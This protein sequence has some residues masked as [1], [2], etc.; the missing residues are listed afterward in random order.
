[1]KYSYRLIRSGRKTIAI[2]L[3]RQGEIL[4]RAPRRTPVKEIDAFFEK[5]EPWIDRHY[6][7]W[8]KK[9][10][11]EAE[12]DP[13][14]EEIEELRKK[15]ADRVTYYSVRMGVA[16]RSVKITSAK[17]RFG[18]CS[19]KDGL[20]FSTKLIPHSDAAID[21]VVVHEL[22]HIR[23]KNHSAAFYREI[24]KIL[25]DYRDRIRL[26]KNEEKTK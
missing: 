9:V 14:A 21:Y 13:T 15:I 2:E 10:A 23:Q 20:C 11:A 24:E 12:F 7:A 25:P 8:Q 5:W 17:T 16:P 18:S 22:A 3:S 1:M 6:D 19:A 26:L 4:V